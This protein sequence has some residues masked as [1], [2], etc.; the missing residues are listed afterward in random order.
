MV[1]LK[2]SFEGTQAL[3]SWAAKTSGL[4][5]SHMYIPQQNLHFQATP[6]KED[7]DVHDEKTTLF[8]GHDDALRSGP[9]PNGC[10]GPYC[11][12]GLHEMLAVEKPYWMA[13][14][15]PDM[16]IVPTRRRTDRDT[17]GFQNQKQGSLGRRMSRPRLMKN[18]LL[19]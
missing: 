17:H 5:A 6:A 16:V 2:R 4:G 13:S 15:H 9:K 19:R 1:G 12:F 8:P 14:I 10:P 7:D 11:G 3:G 18:V